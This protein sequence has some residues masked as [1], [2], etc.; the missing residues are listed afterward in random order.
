MQILGGIHGCDA[1]AESGAGL[2]CSGNSVGALFN[3]G[4]IQ[5][6][7]VQFPDANK[8]NP[9]SGSALVIGGGIDGGFENSGPATSNGATTAATISANGVNSAPTILIDPSQAVFTGTTTPRGPIIIGPVPALVDSVD[10]GYSVLNRG[11]ITAAPTD[12]QI[13]STAIAIVGSSATN[14]TCLSSLVTSC[15]T[16]VQSNGAGGGLLNTGTI[17]ARSGTIQQTNVNGAVTAI[18]LS[19]GAYAIVPRIDVAGEPT[20]GGATTPGA[21]AASVSGEGQGSAAAI[22]IGQNANVPTI[23]VK[24]AW[25]DIGQRQHQH[26]L[27]DRSTSPHT[28]RAFDLISEAIVD[29]SGTLTTINNAGLI[30]ALN[31]QLTPASNAVVVRA[32]PAPS[33][34]RPRPRTTSTS[35]TAASSK[36]ISCSACRAMAMCSMSA[37]SGP[38]PPPIRP[39]TLSTIPTSMR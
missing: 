8:T 19:I 6:V 2:T 25:L 21:I 34:F 31:T 36:A 11:T 15:S 32:S 4:T 37:M 9:E 20:S 27:A 13:S 10:P 30:A 29:S 1:A 33:T 26:H 3:L 39:P 17:I 24:A 16:A 23:D 18:A 38:A 7:G 12:G 35:T 14:Y 5:V 22:V 28:R